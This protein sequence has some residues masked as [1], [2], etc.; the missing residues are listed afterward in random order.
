MSF[1]Y[2]KP[3]YISQFKT[4]F[5]NCGKKTSRGPQNFTR[6]QSLTLYTV[7]FQKR[8]YLVVMTIIRTICSHTM[9]Q[10]SA[11]VFGKGPM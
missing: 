5:L 9:R 2:M 11:K 1:L 6:N 8:P 7:L 4:G 10:K 3:Q